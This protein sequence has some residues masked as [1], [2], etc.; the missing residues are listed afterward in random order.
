MGFKHCD[1]KKSLNN[2]YIACPC[3]CRYAGG[4]GQGAGSWS[5]QSS[6]GNRQASSALQKATALTGKIQQKAATRKSALMESDSDE[7]FNLQM[8]KSIGDM[9]SY[10]LS[11]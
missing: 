8:V 9:V 2:V 6:Q 7:S 10:S 1:Y 11:I 5:L 3:I 4:A